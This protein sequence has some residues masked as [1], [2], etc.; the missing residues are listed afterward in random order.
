LKNFQSKF[1]KGVSLSH[2]FD[3]YISYNIECD[4]GSK[5]CGLTMTIE[6]DTKWGIIELHFYNNARFDYWRYSDPGIV[7]YF[8]RIIYRWKK[9]IKLIFTGKISLENDMVLVD[10]DH[11]NNFI[12]AMQEGRDY[13]INAKNKDNNTS[14]KELNEKTLSL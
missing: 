9:A 1:K 12:E 8:K 14:L 3:D 2:Q 6:C 13:C 10:I 7:N 5:D 11:I 4:C